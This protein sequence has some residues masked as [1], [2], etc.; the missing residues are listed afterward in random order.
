MD[1]Y[2]AFTTFDSPIPYRNINFYPV[3]IKNFYEFYYMSDVLLF[4]KNTDVNISAEEKMKRISMSYLDFLFMLA[5]Q[6][7]QII[8]KLVLLLEL[9][10]KIDRNKDIEFGFDE[11]QRAQIKILV[12]EKWEI[13]DGKDFDE[14][15][16]IICQQNSLELPDE[17][18]QKELRDVLEEAEKFKSRVDGGTKMADL[19]DL[20]VCC[21]I[22]APFKSIEDV[23]NLSIR[24]F[25]KIL[26]RADALISYK[27]LLAASMNGM[28]EIK[29]KSIIR[30]WQ[31]DLSKKKYGDV[32]VDPNK[33]A[34][35]KNL[36]QK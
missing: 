2:D 16:Q 5:V 9:C 32:I 17:K 24:K 34:S 18:T 27:I 4:E 28:V 30:H 6:D 3:S 7:N 10:L 8:V 12:K 11:K 31:S 20:I 22:S 21:L 25:R 19:E 36:G 23:Y 29:D 1:K 13:F 33:L 35:D 14:F 26:E 15:R